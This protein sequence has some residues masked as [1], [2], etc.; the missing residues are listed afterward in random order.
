MKGRL[1]DIIQLV[2]SISEDLLLDD[3]ENSSLTGE[4]VALL[5]GAKHS[6][7]KLIDLL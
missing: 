1:L 5:D 4:Q 2:E 7:T 3:D 6:L